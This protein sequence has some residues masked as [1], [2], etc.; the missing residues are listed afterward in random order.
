[1]ERYLALRL[2][3][4]G[5]AVGIEALGAY[6]GGLGNTRLP[7]RANVAAMLLNVAGNYLL[8]DGRLGA[9]A[10][11]VAGAALASTLSTCLASLGLFLVFVRDCRRHG[12]GRL[13]RP[14]LLRLVRFGLPSGLNWFLEFAAFAFFVNVVVAGLGTTSLAALMAVV[15]LNSA[16]FMPAFG[17]ASAG[18]IL[19]GQAIAFV[20]LSIVH[21]HGR[22]LFFAPQIL[23]SIAAIGLVLPLLLVVVA[24]ASAMALA[25]SVRH[26]AVDWA[27][28]AP[29]ALAGAAGASLGRRVDPGAKARGLRQFYGAD[30]KACK[31]FDIHQT[32]DVHHANV[33]REELGKLKTAGE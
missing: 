15:Q 26:D 20:S 29:F 17:L 21:G 25:A 33:W 23:A 7:M 18:A 4:T 27:V 3:S 8:I 14:E 5:P 13:R 22:V 12:T 11:G 19:A 30:D 1:M 31:Y 24:F 2:L 16:A 28:A 9:P 10:L 32:A 6:Y